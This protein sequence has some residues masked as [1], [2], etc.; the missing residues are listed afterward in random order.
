MAFEER[1]YEG[2]RGSV[3][4]YRA[5]WAEGPGPD[6]RVLVMH[7]A[8]LRALGEHIESAERGVI[9]AWETEM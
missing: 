2:R 4:A 5:Y 9:D 7:S 3:V 1:Y 8:Q 6:L